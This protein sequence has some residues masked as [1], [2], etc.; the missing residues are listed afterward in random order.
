[1]PFTEKTKGPQQ[2]AGLTM[3]ISKVGAIVPDDDS[4][5]EGFAP[6]DALET[7]ADIQQHAEVRHLLAPHTPLF[8]SAGAG[9][10]AAGA[11]V[12]V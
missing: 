8:L 7:D 5:T 6:R 11:F 1:M 4:D 10:G 3:P 2:S 12:C 9:A